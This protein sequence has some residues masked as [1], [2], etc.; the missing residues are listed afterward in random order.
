MHI[1]S[2]FY[3]NNLQIAYFSLYFTVYYA[4]YLFRLNIPVPSTP[5]QGITITLFLRQ[6]IAAVFGEL[7]RPLGRAGVLSIFF[8]IF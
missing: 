5:D 1:S 7:C 8:K 6:F 2:L 4:F 3:L